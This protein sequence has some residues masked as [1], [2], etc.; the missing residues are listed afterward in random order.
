[1][2]CFKRRTYKFLVSSL[3]VLLIP[4]IASANLN[5]SVKFDR[6]WGNAP[7]SNIKALCENVALHFQEQFREKHKINGKLTIVYHSDGPVAFFRNFFGG[8]PDEYQIGLKVTDTF[9]ANFSYQFGHE[10]CHIMTNHD[11]ISPDNPNYWFYESICEL[12]SLW[13]IKE[14]SETWKIRAPYPNWID[15]RHAL[16]NYANHLENRWQVQYSGTGSEWLDEWEEPI[17]RKE[18]GAFDYA[19]VSQLSYKFLTIFQE[20]PEAWNAVRQ[21]PTDSTSKMSI[22]MQKWYNSVDSEDKSVVESIAKEMGIS[23]KSTTVIVSTINADVN[24]DGY[25][26]LYDVLIVRSGMQNPVSYDTDLNDDGVTDEVDLLI[27]KAKAMEAIVAASPRK[28]KVKITTWGA[29]KQQ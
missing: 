10:F 9:W 19:R 7:T 18:P 15:Y 22:Y 23:V 20:N 28:R 4:A 29:A 26:D 21:M 25:V 16:T 5:I 13:V 27:V 11:E 6:G 3:F 14:M 24:D 17:R 2:N 12:A 8:G 1:M